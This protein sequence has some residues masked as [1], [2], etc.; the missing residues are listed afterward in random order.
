M[1]RATYVLAVWWH[2]GMYAQDHNAC[3]M[4]LAAGVGYALAEEF[5]KSGDRVVLC[6]RNGRLHV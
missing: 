5:L 6:S 3:V 4:L 2:N 1:S